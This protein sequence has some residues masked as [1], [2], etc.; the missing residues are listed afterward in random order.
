MGEILQSGG[1]RPLSP[2]SQ[3]G[4]PPGPILG[5]G[6]TR[7]I[8]RVV[9]EA[10]VPSDPSSD[11]LQFAVTLA[12]GGDAKAHDSFIRDVIAKVHARLQRQPRLG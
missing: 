6:G 5:P 2:G 12:D 4:F 7:Y 10:W 8:G 1:S 3:P 11:G 9:I